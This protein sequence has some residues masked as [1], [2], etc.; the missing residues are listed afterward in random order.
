MPGHA[1]KERKLHNEE[2][3]AGEEIETGFEL[4]EWASSELARPLSGFKGLSKDLWIKKDDLQKMPEDDED[5]EEVFAPE[6]S[7]S[8]QSSKAL[9]VQPVEKKPLPSTQVS[10]G[11]T[12]RPRLEELRDKALA[13]ERAA[14]KGRFFSWLGG[15]A[16]RS[17]G[18]KDLRE[19][20][21]PSHEMWI[22]RRAQVEEEGEVQLDFDFRSPSQQSMGQVR[23]KKSVATAVSTRDSQGAQVARKVTTQGS[24]SQI[25]HF[26]S[27]DFH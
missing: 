12:L 26:T 7:R 18:S 24:A 19:R 13:G 4:G 1:L 15:S 10:K 5:P 11:L 22:A 9:D 14:P 16:K 27:Q 6:T 3:T 23:S 20:D 25:L 21:Q 17:T 8:L 2:V